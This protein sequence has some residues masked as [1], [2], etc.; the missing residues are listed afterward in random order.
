MAF[1]IWLRDLSAAIWRSR[2][3]GNRL[4][5]DEKSLRVELA[6]Q[7]IRADRNRSPLAVLIIEL[8][9]NRATP[10]DFG[11]LRRVLVRRL[12]ITDTMGGFSERQVAALLPNTSDAGAWKLASD[13][14]SLYSVG[15]D[16]PNCKVFV[17][18]EDSNSRC[19]SFR[20]REPWPAIAP[21]AR[22]IPLLL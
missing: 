10:V 9:A 4:F 7:Q 20:R 2:N 11:F 14:C 17:Y 1:A 18:P 15:H 12:R 19:D 5:L 6:V 13:I 3:R 8:P 22:L 16:R 21:I